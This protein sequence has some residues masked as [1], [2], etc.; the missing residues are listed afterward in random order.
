LDGKKRTEI[1]IADRRK[2][3]VE[4]QEKICGR[5]CPF[6]LLLFII[7]LKSYRSGG[8]NYSTND[9]IERALI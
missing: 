8:K 3:E 1:E 4:T 9:T 5:T 7:P 2:E 6:Y